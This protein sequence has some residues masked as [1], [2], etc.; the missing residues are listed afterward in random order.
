VNLIIGYR[1]REA[2]G[3]DGHRT[4]AGIAAGN[5]G[6]DHGRGLAHAPIGSSQWGAFALLT[7]APSIG[8]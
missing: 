1:R 7:L 8:S 4:I 3:V 6:H 5:A 2:R